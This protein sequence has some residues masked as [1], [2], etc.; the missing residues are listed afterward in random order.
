MHSF[1]E[2]ITERD[3][4]SCP[5]ITRAQMQ[6]FEG[7]VDQLFKKFGIDFSFTKHF[8][9]R[10]SHERNKPCIDIK[11]IGKMI[12]KIYKK[13]QS[14]NNILSKYK[15]M[16]AVLKDVQSNINIPLALEYDR[17]KD[18]LNVRFLT[19]MRKKGFRSPDPEIRV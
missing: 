16:E 13:K 9:E 17:R 4:G 5:V 18:E 8:R 6:K 12:T 2:F 19:V 15:D 3:T 11:E 10:M 14:G 7:I 1:K